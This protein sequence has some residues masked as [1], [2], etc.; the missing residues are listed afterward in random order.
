MALFKIFK[1]EFAS[2]LNE[3]RPNA[4]EGF[5]YFATNEGKMFI[6]IGDGDVKENPELRVCLN[7]AYADEANRLVGWGKVGY[8]HK[9]I[10]LNDSGEPVEC[11]DV[12]A[13][14][15]AGGLYDGVDKSLRKVGTAEKPVYF[16]DG[17]PVECNETLAINISKNA[18]TA[19]QADKAYEADVAEVAIGAT[20]LIDYVTKEPYSIGDTTL[21]VYF[22]NGYPVQG[23]QFL[24]LSAGEQHKINGPLGFTIEKN[25][26]SS[27]PSTGNEFEG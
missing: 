26:G 21:P 1:G 14:D 6:D 18:A 23:E 3:R 10:W 11:D 13:V 2:T 22:S 16:E 20:Q 8:E 9:P 27:F 17:L 4:N 24:P 5:C 7:A 19:T 12:L 15:I 25:Y